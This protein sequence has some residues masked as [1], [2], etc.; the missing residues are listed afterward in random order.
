MQTRHR[1]ADDGEV[2]AE[3]G[4]EITRVKLDFSV[5]LCVRLVQKELCHHISSDCI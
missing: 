3:F 1:G 5:Y 2:N 4:E